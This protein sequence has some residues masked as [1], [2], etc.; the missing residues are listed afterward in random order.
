MAKYPD[1]CILDLFHKV[2][3]GQKWNKITKALNK[4]YG[5]CNDHTHYRNLY[6]RYK[7]RF[8]LSEN[9]KLSIDMIRQAAT[10]RNTSTKNN[11]KLRE[12]LKQ[13]DARDQ[14]LNDFEKITEKYSQKR[15]I[16]KRAKKNS[17]K[18]GNADMTQVMDISDIHAGL[19]T[20][21]FDYDVIRRR[22]K[23]FTSAFLEEYD[24]NSKTHNVTDLIIAMNGDMIHNDK[25]HEDSV[26]ACS[27]GIPGQ[28]FN[29]TDIL[30]EEVIEPIALIGIPL[31]VVGTAG[32]HDRS[33]KDRSMYKQ[34]KEGYT[35]TVYKTLELL[36]KRLKYKNVKFIIPENYG[37]VVEIQGSNI[38]YE[39]GDM[40]KGNNE[41]S[42]IDH[43]NKRAA[44]LQ[45][46]LHGM[47][48]GHFH[49][50]KQI[51]RKIIVN[52]SLTCGD[53]YS[54]SLGYDT[55]PVQTIVT[56]CKSPNRANSLYR[57]FP[58]LLPK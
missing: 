43:M 25:L 26:K 57:V 47:R 15:T 55:E 42:L 53:D 39:H 20:E 28:M 4:K 50:Y 35:W 8:E 1:E 37:V 2:K 52:G 41:K 10:A 51:G 40:I 14:I 18:V 9:E 33:T 49:E 34:G 19:E 23:A 58:V 48:I 31:R 12:V 11:R 21:N 38:L 54:E 17:L 56:Y 29:I 36:A 13:W 27:E 32:N 3:L 5:F 22:L 7:D 30:F 45:I 16:V 46:V 24:R 6:H 44:A